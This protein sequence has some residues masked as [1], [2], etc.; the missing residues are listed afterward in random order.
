[1][2]SPDLSLASFP[3]AGFTFCFFDFDTGISGR[4]RERMHACNVLSVSTQG[5]SG[6][7]GPDALCPNIDVSSNMDI[8][9]SPDPNGAN[10][11]VSVTALAEGN[12]DDNPK[13]FDE[14]LLGDCALYDTCPADGVSGSPRWD[15][16]DQVKMC[17]PDAT[18]SGSAT[19]EYPPTARA[20]LANNPY[21][22]TMPKFVCFEYP[23]GL[24]G[25]E[26]QYSVGASLEPG[27]SGRNF[28]FSGLSAPAEC[29]DELKP[30]PALK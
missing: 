7:L 23:A 8:E 29:V 17:T 10:R 9:D 1:V 27:F 5:M 2:R 6:S 3:R 28:L 25:F 30:S 18:V 24:S 22:W 4:L 12:G 11:C 15:F 19:G 21:R 16:A 26:V 14:V 20:E 13:F